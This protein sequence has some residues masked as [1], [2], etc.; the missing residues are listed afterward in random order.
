MQGAAGNTN[1]SAIRNVTRAPVII[2]N[3]VPGLLYEFKVV[4][5]SV[6]MITSI[7]LLAFIPNM[8]CRMDITDLGISIHLFEASRV[9]Q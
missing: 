6:N 8:I 2:T 9:I 5:P 7:P 1:H 4:A 3:L